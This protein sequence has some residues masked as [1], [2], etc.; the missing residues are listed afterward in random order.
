MPQASR[1]FLAYSFGIIIVVIVKIIRLISMAY[2]F[3]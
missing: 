1:G 2:I 3:F